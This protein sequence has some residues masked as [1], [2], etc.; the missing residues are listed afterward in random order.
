MNTD[1]SE[2]KFFLWVLVKLLSGIEAELKVT[3]K[4]WMS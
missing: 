1:K 3:T 2:G 4:H